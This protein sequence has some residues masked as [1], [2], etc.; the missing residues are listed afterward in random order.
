[1]KLFDMWEWSDTGMAFL[2]VLGISALVFVGVYVSAP[3]NVDYYYL[4]HG[5][6]S[7]TGGTCVYAHWTWHNDEVAFCTDDRERAID[8]VT[9]ANQSLPKK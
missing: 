1:M 9:R 2:I 5:S 8:F 7:T 6:Q 4:S 3:K